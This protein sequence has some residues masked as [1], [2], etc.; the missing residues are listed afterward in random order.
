MLSYRR[1]NQQIELTN[2]GDKEDVPP[3][4]H[5]SGDPTFESS[6]SQSFV[7]NVQTVNAWL[8]D[9]ELRHAHQ[10][11]EGQN[12]IGRSNTQSLQLND[13][14]VSREHALIVANPND[15]YILRP[16]SPHTKVND[17]HVD[18]DIQLHF[19]DKLQLGDSQ[20]E[21]VDHE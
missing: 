2:F 15:V 7:S 14:T 11:R 4:N 20:F 17:I 13:K 21:F 8:I 6:I 18:E 9:L 5:P 10:L 19:S 16:L 12:S 3:D 1:N